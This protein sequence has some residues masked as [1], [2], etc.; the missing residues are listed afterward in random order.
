MKILE[1]VVELQIFLEGHPVR[2]LFK[3]KLSQIFSSN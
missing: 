3:E 1:Y 2:S